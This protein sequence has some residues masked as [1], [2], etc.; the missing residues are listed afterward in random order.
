MATW[1]SAFLVANVVADSQPKVESKDAV[2]VVEWVAIV[3][4]DLADQIKKLKS[5][6]GKVL[7][8]NPG[9]DRFRRVGD[10]VRGVLKPFL[11][12]PLKVILPG[13]VSFF[14][15]TPEEFRVRGTAHS[16]AFSQSFPIGVEVPSKENVNGGF[17]YTGSIFVADLDN[18]FGFRADR[19]NLNVYY[20]LSQAEPKLPQIVA[21]TYSFHLNTTLHSGE[22]IVSM[23][24]P[25]QAD[26]WRPLFLLVHEAIKVPEELHDRFSCL[27]RVVD[28]VQKGKAGKIEQAMR[29]EAWD[30]R[31]QQDLVE[32]LPEWTREVAEFGGK[33]QL[34]SL[35]R[36]GHAPDISWSPT[37]RPIKTILVSAQESVDCLQA[38]VRVWEPKA[39]RPCEFWNQSASTN[40]SPH[41]HFTVVRWEPG[42]DWKKI[43]IGAGFGPWTGQAKIGIEEGATATI[44]GVEYL[45]QDLI[46]YSGENLHVK[47]KQ[48]PNTPPVESDLW[49]IAVTESGDQISPSHLDGFRVYQHPLLGAGG[50]FTFNPGAVEI[51][52]FVIKT[53]PIQWVEFEN[54]P[55]EMPETTD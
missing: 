34:V 2:L 7:A 32:V 39:D 17:V 38:I 23:I 1:I 40:Q 16:R 30:K 18:Q 33:I 31:P 29:I 35:T 10:E 55:L 24:H 25:D 11:D 48:T 28:W 27:P 26:D 53:R 54:I 42:T 20:S 13:T 50:D 51:D 15:P 4:Q 19:L 22:A 45:R 36:P 9:L 3:D 5:V 37:G 14:P 44:D 8:E 12:Q 43:R 21:G 49:L 47:V 46:R 52:H 6:S 41:A